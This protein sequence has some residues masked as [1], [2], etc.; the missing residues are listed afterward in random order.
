MDIMLIIL[1]LTLSVFF[2]FVSQYL[3]EQKGITIIY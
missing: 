1:M 2:I 3:L